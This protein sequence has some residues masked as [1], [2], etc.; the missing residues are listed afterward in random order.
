MEP[1]RLIEGLDLAAARAASGTGEVLVDFS[2]VGRIDSKT[3]A[4][5]EQLAALAGEHSVKV[6]LRGVHGD[7]YK[8]LKLLK[9]TERFWFVS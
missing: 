1:Q 8:V 3:A 4:A 5:L 7:V 6:A 9:L 2:V